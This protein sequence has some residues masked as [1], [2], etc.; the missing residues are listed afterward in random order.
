[1]I[2]LTSRSLERFGFESRDTVC[3]C[4]NDFMRLLRARVLARDRKVVEQP[5]MRPNARQPAHDD[6]HE[7]IAYAFGARVVNVLNDK[8]IC[9]VEDW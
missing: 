5:N 8:S 3:K 6:R 9:A 4:C 7:S 1:M 2:F